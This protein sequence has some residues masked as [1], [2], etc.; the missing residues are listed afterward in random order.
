MFLDPSLLLPS[1]RDPRSYV[2]FF[3]MFLTLLTLSS[4]CERREYFFFWRNFDGE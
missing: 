4:R 2:F 3:S 1:P